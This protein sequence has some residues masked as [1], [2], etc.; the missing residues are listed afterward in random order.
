MKRYRG[1]EEYNL[2]RSSSSP[3]TNSCNRSKSFN[4]CESCCKCESL[5]SED[6]EETEE[7]EDS[8]D[9]RGSSS[10]NSILLAKISEC[11]LAST[12][13]IVSHHYF[14]AIDMEH[15]LTL[16]VWMLQY[17]IKLGW[18]RKVFHSSL[19]YLDMY[20]TS[21][22]ES[23][24]LTN[25]QL[26]GCCCLWIS[27]KFHLPNTEM[28]DKSMGGKVY[29]KKE[30]LKTQLKILIGI[31]WQL[32]IPP[33]CDRVESFAFLSKKKPEE[34]EK[35]HRFGDQWCLDPYKH[36]LGHAEA[37]KVLQSGQWKLLTDI[38]TAPAPQMS[39][40]LPLY[41]MTKLSLLRSWK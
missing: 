41:N 15:R 39:N 22:F 28:D 23:V 20:M 16:S 9:S 33:L 30:I 6:T 8:E 14:G 17:T 37:L 31:H 27:A 1:T 11:I 26:I 32:S 25:Y 19:D 35:L 34:I 21:N 4:L 13:P 2:Q 5:E 40:R 3:R 18:T 12:C 7:A 29:K 36:E 24:D 38:E 10:E